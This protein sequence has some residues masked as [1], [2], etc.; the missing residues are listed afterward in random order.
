MLRYILLLFIVLCTFFG[1]SQNDDDIIIKI[2]DQQITRAEFVRLY[3]KNND[4]LLDESEKKTPKEYLDL[5]INFKLKVLEAE[6][7]GYDTVPGFISELK[8][9]REELAKPYLTAVK[10]TNKMVETAY[11]RMKTEVNASHILLRLPPNATPADTLKA[12]NKLIEIRQKIKSG[13]DFNQMAEK[14]SEDPSAKTNQGNLG[15]FTAFQMVYP[16]EDAAYK[17]EIGELSQPVRTNFGYHLIKVNNKRE[18]KGQ[19][20]VAHIMK[21]LAVNSSEETIKRQKQ[22]IDS[23]AMELKNGADFAELAK[24]N[25]DDRRS[26]ANGGA[27][28]WFGSSGMLPEF[29]NPAFALKN[30]GDVSDVIRTPYGWHII[31]RIESRPIPSYDEIKDFL[32]EKI[33]KN[34][35]ISDHSVEIFVKNLKSE[36]HF[37]DSQLLDELKKEV[38]PFFKNNRF[39]AI[40]LQKPN[41]EI[42]SFANVKVTADE[43]ANYL[44][45][46]KTTKEQTNSQILIDE[47]Y[48][49]FITQ[50]LLDYENDHLE[51]KYPEFKFLVKEYHDGILLFNISEDKIWNAAAQDSIGL[52]TFYK[53]N[54]KKY[55]W[56][57][58]FKGWSIKC[59]KQETRDFIDAVFEE[60][61][62]I[63]AQELRDQ[64][65]S[66]LENNQVELVFGYFE[67]GMDSLVD[68]LVWNSQ[69]P[70]DYQEGLHFVRGD[71]V[72]PQPKSLEEAKGLY[73]SDYQNY[74]EKQWIKKLRKEYKIRVRKRILREVESV[75]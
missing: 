49:N 60:D 17:T 59:K 73:I 29:A 27:L 18:A 37:K 3:Q 51:E 47:L 26:A 31:K 21:R 65:N 38:E 64:V 9:Y 39:D 69:K 48:Q 24:E 56:D 66:H 61:P 44:E 10:Y 58:R 36:Y 72:A 54:A 22:V 63:Q 23:L 50:K 68:Y 67:K 2:D 5:F 6:R 15:Y 8:N 62:D 16:F 35:E 13:A 4:H 75:K 34:P 19:I 74:L 14:Y 42:F 7:L 11:Q 71:K 57:E 25:S 55:T 53:E 1:F 33:R 32:T 40:N 28:S 70:E 45:K 30:D 43:F 41:Q 20:K 12:W 46:N 52:Q